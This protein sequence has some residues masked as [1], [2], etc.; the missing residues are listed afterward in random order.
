MHTQINLQD[1]VAKL[2]WFSAATT[3]DEQFLKHVKPKKGRIAVFHK[4]YN[5]Y[6]TFDKLK[7]IGAF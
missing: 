7:V 4:G 2:I 6:K 3:H 5:D 1:R